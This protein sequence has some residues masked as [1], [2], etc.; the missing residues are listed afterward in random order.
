MRL[1]GG[2]QLGVARQ[3]LFGG[4]AERP[5]QVG[6]RLLRPEPFADQQAAV[7]TDQRN[8]PLERRLKPAEGVSRA[9]AGCESEAAFGLGEPTGVE[10]LEANAA[11][12][13]PCLGLRPG[14]RDL[15]LARSTPKPEAPVSSA[16]R[17]RSSPRPQPTSRTRSPAASGSRPMTV[18]IGSLPIGW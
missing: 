10:C 2:E 15:V 9:D 12:G 5:K 7:R 16:I 8:E 3:L 17:S 13:D 11:V 4:V 1:A 14:D 18:S 6:G